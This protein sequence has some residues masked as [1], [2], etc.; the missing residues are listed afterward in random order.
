MSR[1]PERTPD[2]LE[3]ILSAIDRIQQYLAGK[4]KA[5]FTADMILQDAVLRNLGIIGEASRKILAASPD[6]AALHP[7]I[8]L[9]KINATRNRI[10]HDYEEVDLD[11]VW[12]L[13]AHDVTVLRPSIVTALK[14]FNSAPPLPPAPKV[15]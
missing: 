15:P 4:S 5:D 11:I 1:H 6:F 14:E 2:Y 9:A 3:H 12:N 7:E 13:V 10:V 8:P